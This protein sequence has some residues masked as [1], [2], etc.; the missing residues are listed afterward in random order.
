M[1]S[2]YIQQK[3]FKILDHYPITDE[4]GQTIYQVDQEFNPLGHTVHVSAPNGNHL[5][6]VDRV[7]LTL[8][9][10]FVVTF[11]NGKEISIQSNFSLLYRDIDIDPENLGLNVMGDFWE[12]EYTLTQRG[13]KV[14]SISKEWLTLADNYRLDIFDE[15]LQDLFVAVVIAID[16]LLDES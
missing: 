8:L 12:H 1:K 4:N 5:F 14:G 2:L 11:A 6:T 7:V 16:C 3:V 10:K 9:P 13:N 15:S